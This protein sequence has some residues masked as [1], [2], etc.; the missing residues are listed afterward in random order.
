MEGGK[1]I[2]YETR[3]LLMLLA[4]IINQ[5]KIKNPRRQLN[6]ETLLKVADYQNI[7]VPIYCGMLGVEKEVADDFAERFHQKYQKELLLRESYLNAEEVIAWQLETHKIHA[8]FLWGSELYNFYPQS[9]LEYKEKIE[10]VVE[11]KYLPKVHKFMRDMNYEKKEDRLGSG[12]IYERTPG[13]RIVFYSE[14]PIGNKTLKKYFSDPVRE[15]ARVGKNR[16]IHRLIEE[17]LYLYLAGRLVELFIIGEL[18]IREIMDWMQYRKNLGEGFPWKETQSLLG[19]AKFEEFIHQ[20]EVLS[21]I[22]FE[23]DSDTEEG[24]ITLELEEYI[25]SPG[26]EN[27]WLEEKIL[28]HERMRL[29][30]YRRNREEEWEE[31]KKGWWFPSKEYM[32]SLFPVLNKYPFLLGFF[33]IVRILRL[34]GN[35]WKKAMKRK[36]LEIKLKLGN[37]IGGKRKE[38][39]KLNGETE[40]GS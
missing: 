23:G 15:Y 22:W 27:R 20:V 29:D 26:R 7:V 33:L 11:E 28:P 18:K 2:N 16:Y 40:N 37:I 36:W 12:L 25:L 38:Q 21:R 9:E 31:K 34:F 14:F 10:I 4:A 17:E 8:V 13:I 39:E 24:T 3:Y 35:L 1:D 6:W 32:A 5:D 30:F 19:K